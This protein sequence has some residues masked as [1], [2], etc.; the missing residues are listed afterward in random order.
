MRVNE[1]PIYKIGPIDSLCRSAARD[2]ENSRGSEN[3]YYEEL[4]K[5]IH[6]QFLNNPVG[7]K[8]LIYQDIIDN[9]LPAEHFSDTI[10]ITF[11]KEERTFSFDQLKLFELCRFTLDPDDAA[12]TPG[13]VHALNLAK[14]PL[15]IPDVNGKLFTANHAAAS[16]LLRTYFGI[17]RDYV[18]AQNRL[19]EFIERASLSSAEDY[20][21]FWKTVYGTVSMLADIS[22]AKL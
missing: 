7:F 22:H 17:H 2:A 9:G 3:P 6:E 14:Y 16:M 12:V 4:A 15:L 10:T 20:L 1:S 19:F 18:E 11:R 13:R 21:I 8:K 5:S